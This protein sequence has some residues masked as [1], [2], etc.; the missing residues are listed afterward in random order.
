MKTLLF[1]WGQILLSKEG[2][3]KFRLR[4]KVCNIW[5][6]P[7]ELRLKLYVVTQSHLPSR[8]LERS[9]PLVEISAAKFKILEANPSLMRVVPTNAKTG[10]SR[11]H[12]LIPKVY[13]THYTRVKCVFLGYGTTTNKS[14]RA[15]KSANRPRHRH[16]GSRH[17]SARTFLFCVFVCECEC[18]GL[19]MTAPGWISTSSR[20]GDKAEDD[21]VVASWWDSN[22]ARVREETSVKTTIWKHF[23]WGNFLHESAFARCKN[24]GL[25]NDGRL[26]F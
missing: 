4:Q 14:S 26:C 9:F 22:G 5:E 6:F 23:P 19:L 24:C 18:Y 16:Y 21:V 11:R 1:L 8:Q 7:T 20:W 17:K 3:L 15:L 13:R 10:S 25:V 2:S 12:S